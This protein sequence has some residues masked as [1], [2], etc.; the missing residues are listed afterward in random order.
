M[1]ATP[2]QRKKKVFVIVAVVFLAIMG[3]IGYDISSRT[4]FPGS[5]G[6]LKGRIMGQDSVAAEE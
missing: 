5:E 1:T 3:L 4:T 2:N 6:N